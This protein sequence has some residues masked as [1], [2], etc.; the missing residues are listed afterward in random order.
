VIKCKQIGLNPLS[1]SELDIDIF[2]RNGDE[3]DELTDRLPRILH[4]ELLDN[5]SRHHIELQLREPPTNAGPGM[6][7][8][9]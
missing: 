8:V 6:S 4:T 1:G 2:V 5:L 7:A 3:L 9:K